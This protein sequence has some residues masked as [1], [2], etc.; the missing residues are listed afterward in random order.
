[1]APAGSPPSDL[2]PVY[3]WTDGAPYVIARQSVQ[4]RFNTYMQA[5]ACMLL[6]VFGLCHM[7]VHRRAAAQEVAQQ[8]RRVVLVEMAHL[9]RTGRA[10]TREREMAEE[11]ANAEAW[12][13]S[14]LYPF[15]H[16]RGEVAGMP[17]LVQVIQPGDA[18]FELGVVVFEKQGLESMPPVLQPDSICGAAA[19]AADDDDDDDDG[20]HPGDHDGRLSSATLVNGVDASTIHTAD[21]AKVD[22]VLDNPLYDVGTIDGSLEDVQAV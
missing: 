10:V 16:M 15:W 11:A 5:F 14:W 2:P 3:G 12:E 20:K 13:S 9:R 4:S 1:M 7:A 19:A 6:F 17:K 22:G 18:N 8:R 21:V